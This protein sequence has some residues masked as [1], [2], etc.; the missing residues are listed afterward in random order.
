MEKKF[1][2]FHPYSLA[3]IVAVVSFG[4]LIYVGLIAPTPKEQTVEVK[5]ATTQNETYSK[6]PL[7][8]YGMDLVVRDQSGTFDGRYLDQ[9]EIEFTAYSE[10]TVTYD[11]FKLTNKTNDRISLRI[12]PKTVTNPNM[13]ELEVRMLV[14]GGTFELYSFS[15]KPNQDYFA[16]SLDPYQAEDIKLSVTAD[17]L[18]TE[19]VKGQV[20][21]QIVEM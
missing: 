3:V 18:D 1:N 15:K 2:L 12:T 9:Q 21:F 17:V 19:T 10:A 5:G 16:I 11:L 6:T 4:T 14:D 20:L 7:I 13:N 8:N